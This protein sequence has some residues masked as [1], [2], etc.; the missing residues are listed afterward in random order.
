MRTAQ[1]V[2]LYEDVIFFP[3][4]TLAVLLPSVRDIDVSHKGLRGA[5]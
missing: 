1:I 4:L 2:R 5:G 3:S